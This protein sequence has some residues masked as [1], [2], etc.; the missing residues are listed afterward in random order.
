M[1]IQGEGVI[2]DKIYAHLW[3]KIAAS[4][5]DKDASKSINEIIKKMTT[6]EIAI[7]EELNRE[8]IRKNLKSC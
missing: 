3:W 2:K 8:C 5:G 6:K 4:N 1:Y 7:A